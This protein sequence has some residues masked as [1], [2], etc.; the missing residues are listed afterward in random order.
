[1]ERFGDLIH[2]QDQT[3]FLKF[4]EDTTKISIW[5]KKTMYIN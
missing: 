3:K 4:M 5:D 1:M 2:L